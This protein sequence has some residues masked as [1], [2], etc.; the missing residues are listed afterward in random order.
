M[1]NQLLDYISD[2]KDLYRDLI[3]TLDTNP[4]N[5]I[6]AGKDGFVVEDLKVNTAYISFKNKDKAK[7]VLNKK[8]FVEYISY[9]KYIHEILNDKPYFTF[10]VYI[11]PS[12]NK[13]LLNDDLKLLVLKEKDIDYFF[14]NYD[15]YSKEELIDDIKNEKIF[16][17]YKDNKIIGFIGIHRE[18]SLGLIF[19]DE[20]YRRL[21]YGYILEA[22]LINK[23]IDEGKPVWCEINTDNKISQRLCEKLGFKKVGEKEVYWIRNDRD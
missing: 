2:N 16:G 14:N 21:G 5:I 20:N 4:Y 23:L 22:K 18:G 17:L 8:S 1:I 19:I 9:E 15:V 10:N 7:E 13:I 3:Y 11:Y 12:K 6:Y